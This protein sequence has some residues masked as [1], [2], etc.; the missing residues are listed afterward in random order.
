MAKVSLVKKSGQKITPTM[1]RSKTLKQ[2]L[3]AKN[4]EEH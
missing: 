2:I 3:M 4:L 1:N